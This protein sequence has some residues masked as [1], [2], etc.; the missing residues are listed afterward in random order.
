VERALQALEAAALRTMGAFEAQHVAN[1]LHTMAE[2]RYRPLDLSLFPELERRAE[3]VAG[4]FKAQNVAN[5]LWAYATMGREPA[6]GL[7]RELEGRA[8]ATLVPRTSEE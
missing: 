5:T 6:A 2:N 3:A 7:M 1:T 4:T 8:E